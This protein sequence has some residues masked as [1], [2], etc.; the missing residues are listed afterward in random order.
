MAGKWKAL[1]DQ[2][3]Q[4]I[5]EGTHLPGTAL[6]KIPDMV[7]AGWG[8]KATVSRAY[9]ELKARGYVTA[10]RGHGTVVRDRS[11]VR[12]PLSRYDQVL[13]PGGTRGPWETATAAQGL[14]G[15]MEVDKPAAETVDVPADIAAGLGLDAP[16]QAVRRRRRAMIDSDTVALQEA[17]YPRDIAE[18][19]GLDRLGKITGGALG[20]LVGAGIVPAE[21]EETVTADEAT[22]DQAARLSIATR[23]PV[24][25]VDRVT[26][27]RTG[28]VIEL[29]RMTGA[30]DRLA[31]V[32]SPLPLKVRPS[33]GR[34]PA[35]GE[36]G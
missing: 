28:R 20:A 5:K 21:A 26:R 19:A 2:L 36:V 16:A 9:E 25:I 8:S 13:E 22:P 30:A 12:V 31:L 27:D 33:R 23:A 18:A 6:P 35:G 15:R 3:E 32:Y 11:R 29:V 7:A 4:E 34:T 10:R 17:W 24:F 14:N 1:A